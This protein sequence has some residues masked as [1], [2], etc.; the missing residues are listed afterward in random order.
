MSDIFVL[1]TTDLGS[2]GSL[3]PRTLRCFGP[4]RIVLDQQ[5]RVDSVLTIE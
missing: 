4:A 2:E 1:L 3:R 5:W